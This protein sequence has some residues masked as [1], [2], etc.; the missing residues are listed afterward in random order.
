MNQTDLG[1]NILEQLELEW[2]GLCAGIRQEKMEDLFMQVTAAAQQTH[3]QQLTEAERAEALAPHD[4]T[5]QDFL[6][7]IQGLSEAQWTF[8]PGPQ[9]WSI[10]EVAEHVTR[11]EAFLGGAIAQTMEKDPD[12]NLEENPA[13][14]AAIKAMVLDRSIRRVATSGPTVPTGEWTVKETVQRYKDAHAQMRE[15]LTRPGLPLKGRCFTGPPGTFT[16]HH[17][18]MLIPM[19]TRRHLA[20]IADI[21]ATGANAGFPA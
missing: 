21:K 2:R 6:A 8:K 9:R 10:Q 15:L 7:A 11:V 13:A 5:E 16:C 20:Q 14:Y 18:L 3:E 1:P 4:Q 17:F 12:P 19:H